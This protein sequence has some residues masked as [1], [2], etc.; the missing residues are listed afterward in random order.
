MP[1]LI[2]CRHGSVLAISP[3]GKRVL[4]ASSTATHGTA[5]QM[6]A[7]ESINPAELFLFVNQPPPASREKGSLGARCF[8]TLEGSA[9]WTRMLR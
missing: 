7:V 6:L 1:A 8:M 3:S 5:R 2:P 9:L 4:P